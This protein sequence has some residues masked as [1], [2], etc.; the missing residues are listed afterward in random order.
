MMNENSIK[1]N[2]IKDWAEDDRPREKMVQKGYAALSDAELLAILIQ[3]GTKEKSAVDLAREVLQLGNQNLS[4]LGKLALKDFQAI[5]GIGEARSITI[6]AALELGR[7]RQLS[8][9]MEQKTITS[10]KHAADILMPLMSDLSHEKFVILCLSKSNK[11]LH[12]EFVSSGGVAGTVV[13]PKMIFKIA[14]QHL[15]S[16]LIIGH[17]HPSGNLNPSRADKTIT[18]KIKGGTLLLEMTLMDHIIIADNRY[19]SFADNGI[20]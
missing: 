11:L 5:K 10:S 12:L 6:A 13:D 16:N 4:H 3:S 14:L 1:P 15:T 20:L 19:Y 8:G 2:T 18:E 7:R 17:N 9:S